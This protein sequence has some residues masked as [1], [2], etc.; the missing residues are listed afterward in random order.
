MYETGDEAIRVRLDELDDLPTVNDFCRAYYA[1]L[2]QLVAQVPTEEA[3]RLVFAGLLDIELRHHR[4][5]QRLISQDE[6]DLAE[7]TTAAEERRVGLESIL[8]FA[9]RLRPP[10]LAA[11]GLRELVI[12]ECHY[13]LHQTH[14]CVEALERAIEAGVRV[15]LVQF[16]LGYNR[17]VDAL[18]SWSRVPEGSSEPQ[19]TDPL[20]FQL[21]CLHAVSALEDGLTGGE[22]D[23]HLYW[24]IGNV[25]DV[26]GLTDAAADAYDKAAALYAE[27]GPEAGAV[28]PA[29]G[30]L[31]ENEISEAEVRQA[32]EW[33]K[34]RFKAADIL[35]ERPDEG[36]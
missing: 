21:H 25:L 17:Y 18:E 32:V 6:L 3:V 7:M 19:I 16:A 23:G 1:L 4:T 15:P 30:A 11:E 2:G 9:S 31:S 27:E 35:R 12:A 10:E 24:W 29:E 14:K 13:H 34:G 20:S 26:V 36:S 33:L 8:E 22:M 5:L 28:S